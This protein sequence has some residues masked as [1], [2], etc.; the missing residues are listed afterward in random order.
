M[1][2]NDNSDE[3]KHRDTAEKVLACLSAVFR[4]GIESQ[5]TY[6]HLS[7]AIGLLESAV[8]VPPHH[9]TREVVDEIRDSVVEMSDRDKRHA[10]QLS[11]AL[12]IAAASYSFVG[13][14]RE[15]H[16]TELKSFVSQSR[17]SR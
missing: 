17:K 15:M 13:R 2:K 7:I 8:Q 10:R 4:D 14:T 6:A 16:H 12:R 11:D 9:L 3:K 1:A 5:A